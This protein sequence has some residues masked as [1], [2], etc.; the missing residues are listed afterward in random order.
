MKEEVD[1]LSSAELTISIKS[2]VEMDS[3]L[4]ISCLLIKKETKLNV[5]ILK[6]LSM[7]KKRTW[8]LGDI[9]HSQEGKSPKWPVIAR[10]QRV[11]GF[12]KLILTKIL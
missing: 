6:I 5:C 8:K 4:R 10:D 2:N 11:Q 9:T 1:G 3:L 7:V 12:F